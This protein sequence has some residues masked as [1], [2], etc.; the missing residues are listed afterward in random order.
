[1]EEKMIKSLWMILIC[2]CL[3]MPAYSDD[4]NAIL[5]KVDR[6][7]N[8]KA[9]E[10]YRKLI[11]LEP[12]GSKKEFI[13]YSVKKGRDQIASVFL[14]PASEKGRATLRL[15]ENMW[16]YIPNVGKPIRIT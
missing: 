1:M 12:D 15:G 3:A 8:P 5:Q 6:N 13:M 10:M 4:G 11:N 2:L 16:L 7:L 14:S 9:F